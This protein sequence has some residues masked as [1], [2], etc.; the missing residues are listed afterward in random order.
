MNK[1]KI[2]HNEY[3]KLVEELKSKVRSSQLRAALSVNK[4]IIFL[5]FEIGKSLLIKQQ[6]AQWGD[7]FL[8]KVVLDLKKEFP[9]MKGLS[10]R[11][12]QYMRKF[13]NCF[14][15]ISIAQQ[16]A[17]Q[18][19]VPWGHHMLMLDKNLSPSVYLWYSQQII[20]EGWSRSILGIK[21]E[22]NTYERQVITQQTTN[23]DKVLPKERS[24]VA[25]A[26][27]KD[28]YVLNFIDSYQNEKELEQE[29]IKHIQ[30]FLIELGKG[31]SFVGTQYHLEVGG[32]DFYI[33][34]L[35]YHLELRCFVVIELKTGEFKPE[36]SGKMQ[37]YLTAL[38]KEVKHCSDSRSIGIIL[39]KKKNKIV[40]EYALHGVDAPMGISSYE[41]KEQL[42][43]KLK[44]C[45]PTPEELDREFKEIIH[46]GT[47]IPL[48][49]QN[50]GSN[51]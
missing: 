17:A 49:K 40:A 37:F 44:K 50:Y 20:N 3:Y 33:D 25:N 19:I 47:E 26:V 16:T 27:L 36:Y 39:C 43:D 45:F 30:K 2:D 28:S 5:Y 21:I 8:E 22:N 48:K 1:N 38:D 15:E 31:F 34:M 29:L 32:Q 46:K 9:R 35:F 24:D 6:E 41:I 51:T 18:L 42:P 12:M 4:E 11:N 10:V 7:K 13:A 23:F 14:K